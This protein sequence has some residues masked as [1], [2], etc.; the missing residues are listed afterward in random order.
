[1]PALLTRMSTPPHGLHDLGDGG[2][3]L[4]LV[5]DVHC[6]RH[7]VGAD[8]GGDVLGGG[9]VQVG[10]RDLRAF[11]RIDV[12]DVLAEAAR[13]TGDDCDLVLQLLAHATLA[14]GSWVGVT[15]AASGRSPVRSNTST[16]LAMGFLCSQRGSVRVWVV[17]AMPAAQCSSIE[18]RENS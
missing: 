12:G 2:V 5:A 9:E 18:V 16:P 7:R 3:D 10:D 14:P 11:A 13:G 1:M 17:S 6:D 8:L 15:V 4:R